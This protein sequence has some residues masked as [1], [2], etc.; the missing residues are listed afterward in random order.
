VDK[1]GKSSPAPA[2]ARPGARAEVRRRPPREEV[3][4][5]V[6]DAAAT[7]FARRGID[8]ASL[9]DV[10]AE[11]GFTKGAVYSNF[12]SKDG[13]VE[14]LLADKAST[15]LDLGL[16]AVRDHDVPLVDRARLLGDRLSALDGQEREWHLLFHELWQRAARGQGLEGFRR[17]RRAL[18]AAVAEAV[19]EHADRAGT[20]LAL[21]P[22]QAAT[23][24]LA[25]VQGLAAEADV[26]PDA[27]PPDL[28][29][30]VLALLLAG[31]SLP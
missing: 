1:P 5:A 9:D 24:L 28:L 27:V 4:R 6:L 15:Y 23:V 20:P 17:H 19:A 21:P 16:E 13:L 30:K 31:Q 29:G 7:V 2:P 11:A 12:G 22:D 26:D 3:R 25:L 18:R 8:G 14:A 10:A